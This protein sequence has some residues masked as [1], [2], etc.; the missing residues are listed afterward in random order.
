VTTA[1]T[2]GGAT[3]TA[4]V[5]AT[6]RAAP[7]ADAVVVRIVEPPGEDTDGWTFTPARLAVHVGTTVVWVNTGRA[8]HSATADDGSRFDSSTLY[9]QATFRFT[10]QH[11]GAIAYHCT[12]HPWM[13]GTLVVQP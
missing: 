5:G 6:A 2:V 11:A 13:Q 8:P 1:P 3:V 7:E 12:L 4:S 10:P 9:P